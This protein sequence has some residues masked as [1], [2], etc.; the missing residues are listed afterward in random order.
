ML[1]TSR[2]PRRHA[3]LGALALLLAAMGCATSTPTSKSSSSKDPFEKYVWPRPPNPARI[4]LAGI[5][6]NR[7]DVEGESGFSKALIAQSD[8]SPLDFLIKP[9]A[10]DFDRA[11]RILVTDPQ[12][13]ALF[14]I[15]RAGHRWDVAGTTTTPKLKVP[16]GLAVGPDGRIYV[17]DSG[18]GQIVVFDPDLEEIVGTFGVP[19]KELQR[20][21]DVAISRD[22]LTAFVV[23]SSLHKVLRFDLRSGKQ[24][25]SIGTRGTGDGEFNFP[26]ALATDADGNLFVIDSMN[27]RLQIFA[28]DGS[29]LDQFGT[30]ST[31]FGGFVR[32]K[33]VAI[34]DRGFIY[35]TDAAFN[36]I[37]IFSPELDL[38]TFVGQGGTE[39]DSFNLPTGVKVRGDEIAVVDQ[40]R[41]RVVVFRYIESPAGK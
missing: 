27:S 25:G 2:L 16:L 17:A 3:A 6:A 18:I 12:K 35:V 37:Q 8:M 23:D 5:W 1:L 38:L 28:P 4:R 22:G 24:V 21:T 36:N 39:L 14:R 15:D 7:I 34:D 11:G 40:I 30:L 31:T 41:G 9:F 10:V 33:D 20:P 19:G 26:V 29:Y 13:A 32:P